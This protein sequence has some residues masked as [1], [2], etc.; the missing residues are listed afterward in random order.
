MWPRESVFYRLNFE[1]ALGKI[2]TTSSFP[3]GD[4][5]R[6]G[7]GLAPQERDVKPSANA[8]IPGCNTPNE[9]FGRPRQVVVFCLFL[10]VGSSI[11]IY[12]LRAGTNRKIYSSTKPAAD[13]AISSKL[14]LQGENDERLK[15]TKPT[16]IS[17]SLGNAGNPELL[18]DPK[19]RVAGQ[20]EKQKSSDV[21]TRVLGGYVSVLDNKPLKMN[22]KTCALVS[23]S[24]RILKQNKGSEIDAADCVFRMN[25]APVKGFET[26]VGHKTTVR[27]VSQFSVL[28]CIKYLQSN[29][30]D[31]LKFFIAWGSGGHLS[32]KSDKYKAMLAAAEKN[33]QIGFYC[34]S[35]E[36]YWSQDVVFKN[37][38]G[39]ERLRSGSWL[40]TGWFTFDVLKSACQRTKIYGMIPEDYCRLHLDK[41]IHYGL[42][43]NV[44]R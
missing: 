32:P 9:M 30:N 21:G 24:G 4:R 11:F 35:D 2:Q 17:R 31:P 40:T 36:H 14:W 16:V 6:G 29:L 28:H 38:T 33:P 26:D 20:G 5:K 37:E 7:S 15:R 18:H 19:V 43:Y 10:L 27:I 1:E 44:F 8:H 13:W 42:Y 39:Q 3:V 25:S 41:K 34:S 22:C 23:S 12:W